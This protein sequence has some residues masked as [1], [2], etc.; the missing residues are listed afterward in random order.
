VRKLPEFSHAWRSEREG[1]RATI[2]YFRPSGEIP[3]DL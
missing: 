2:K 3:L 1:S